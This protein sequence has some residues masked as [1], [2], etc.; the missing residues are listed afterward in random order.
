MKTINQ[1]LALLGLQAEDV[2]TNRKG[3]ITTVSFDLYGCVQ[4]VLNQG[5]DKDGKSKEICWFDVARL[6]VLSETPVMEQPD[7]ILKSPI[8]PAEKPLPA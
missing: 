2:I 5:D 1:H 8:G 6:K 3:I 4:A 7:F